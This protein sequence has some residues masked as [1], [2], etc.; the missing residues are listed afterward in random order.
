MGRIKTPISLAKYPAFTLLLL[1]I[2]AGTLIVL[3]TERAETV[4]RSQIL[5]GTFVEIKVSGHDR[6]ALNHAI[7]QAF[8]EI[9]RIDREMGVRGGGELERVNQSVVGDPI[10]ISE[11]LF[12][13]LS[14]A[15]RFHRLTDGKFD[16]SVGRLVETWRFGYDGEETE[17]VE[18]YIPSE[19]ELRRLIA[20]DDSI[21]LDRVRRTV[22][23]TS[24]TA[25]IDL[26]GI[27]KG[28]AADRAM[29][30]LKG[31][32]VEAALIDAGGD[33]RV[34]NRKPVRSLLFFE[35]ERP[36]Q[37]G[38]QHPRV[39]RK[40]LGTIELEGD[41]A[42]AT[43]GDYQQY[44]IV[45]GTRYHHILDPDTGWPARRAISVTVAAP[46]AMAADAL[47]TGVFVLG[48]ES[49]M[50]LIERLDEVEGV[51]V[52]STGE[53]LRSSGLQDVELNF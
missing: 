7:D 3:R 41:R 14:E 43:S 39:E 34:Y 35:R 5:L 46:T 42:V 4:S 27:A 16:V 50:I 28:Y 18:G 24:E 1:L 52:T 2:I 9:S 36:F 8:A 45:D 20:E 29:E 23:L 17:E 11:E 32:G 38:I 10:L 47:S 6:A 15:E 31:A 51:I 44:R 33:I 13:I 26:G 21:L 40:L 30:V 48:P 12:T 37:I 53:I 49:G 25:R 22:T 19:D